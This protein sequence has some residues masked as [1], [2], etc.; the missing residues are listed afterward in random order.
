MNRTRTRL[1]MLLAL[2]G[3]A[4]AAHAQDFTFE[5]VSTE[6]IDL[7]SD[8]V[9]TPAFFV[10]NNP[11]SIAF[12][13]DDLYVGGFANFSDPI[14]GVQIVQIQDFLLGTA[15][16][17]FAIV[18]GSFAASSTP[19]T[20]FRGW[21][22][23][24]WDSER[25]LLG[26]VDFGSSG[27]SN[28]VR[29]F[30]F[31]QSTLGGFLTTLDLKATSIDLRGIAGPSWDRG[32]NASGFGADGSIVAAVLDP[33][34]G[35]A[36]EKNGPFGH[37]LPAEPDL[38]D[39][40]PGLDSF[41]T[42]YFPPSGPAL[43]QPDT[44]TLWRDLDVDP[45]TGD[46]AARAA[47]ILV[48]GLRGADGL[49]ASSVA[50]G[51]DNAPFV[52]GQNVAILHGLMD[53]DMVVY[54]D[55]PATSGGQAFNDVIKFVDKSGASMSVDIVDSAGNPVS[56]PAG[57]GYYD[58]A[59]DEASQTLCILDFAAR[60]VYVLQPFMGSTCPCDSPANLN[61]DATLNFFDIAAYIQNYNAG[62]PSADLAA[63]F[64]TLNFFDISTFIGLFNAGCP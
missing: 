7:L 45:N 26:T 64:G 28:Q 29:I 50:V 38:G 3:A 47:N 5:L 24:D 61:C 53:G 2:A 22:G 44:S 33:F 40:I 51:T 21:T 35:P 27:A 58:F 9:N 19:V 30:N 60:D 6:E 56:L 49:I 23:L 14:P 20:N 8:N 36:D 11:S 32:F 25:G 39:P 34:T 12:D 59:W 18:E 4:A 52:S 57:V 43:I 48:I 17:S 31:K 13:G 62:D 46:M 54:N 41:V 16:R 63:P 42:A 15:G 1:A 37:V 10:G 55:R